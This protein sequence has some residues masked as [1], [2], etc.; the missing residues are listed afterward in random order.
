MGPSLTLT[1]MSSHSLA[2]VEV[3]L[4]DRRVGF[5]VIPE[6]LVDVDD[7]PAVEVHNG[8]K[9]ERVGVVVVQR[10]TTLVQPQL[11]H[12]LL[13]EGAAV[14]CSRQGRGWGGE[15]QCLL[16]AIRRSCLYTGRGVLA[17]LQ[18]HCTLVR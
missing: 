8:C 13:L 5:G 15:F 11:D 10:A 4:R 12:P 17:E 2:V 9:A 1:Q 18:L 7:L 16:S 3:L 14:H 6:G